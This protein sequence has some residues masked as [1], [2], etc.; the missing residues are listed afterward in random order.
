MNKRKKIISF[1]LNGLLLIVILILLIPSWRF[2]FQA[3]FQ[4]KTMSTTA[5]E[6]TENQPIS[7]STQQWILVDKSLKI[8]SF[9]SFSDQPIFLNFWATWCVYCIAEFPHIQDLYE[10]YKDKIHFIAVS[11]ESIETIEQ[12]GLNEQYDFLYSSQEIPTDFDFSGYPT[13]FIIDANAVIIYKHVG[14]ADVDT[15]ENRNFLDALI[16]NE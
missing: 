7:T 6:F 1:T 10:S 11:T 12:S 9:S 2:K 14:A 13:T 16:K 15:E 4:E 3:W 8:H 5:F